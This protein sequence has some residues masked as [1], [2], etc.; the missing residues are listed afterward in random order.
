MG[1]FYWIKLRSWTVF[2]VARLHYLTPNHKLAS[3]TLIERNW[4]WTVSR[5]NGHGPWLTVG[6]SNDKDWSVISVARSSPVQFLIYN[7]SL[8]VLSNYLKYFKSILKVNLIYK[9]WC[10]Y[11]IVH[12]LF[13]NNEVTYSSPYF[14]FSSFY[15][16]IFLVLLNISHL[17]IH[18]CVYGFGY[19]V[20]FIY[21]LFLV[22]KKDL[23]LYFGIYS[24]MRPIYVCCQ[25]HLEKFLLHILERPGT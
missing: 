21:K 8:A 13:Y 14:F 6:Q 10:E 5:P 12:V 25:L 15:L 18:N 2:R 3:Q 7:S 24:L 22:I 17:N 20:P 23:V 11:I 16:M 19:D 1:F 9:H 4:T